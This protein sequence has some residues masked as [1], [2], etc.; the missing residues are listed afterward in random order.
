MLKALVERLF[1]RG[2]P[3][4]Y[5]EAR[6]LARN[7]PAE[8]RTEMAGRDDT[9]PEILYYLAKDPDPEVRRAVAAN[10][11]TPPHANLLLAADAN[12]KVRADLAGKIG[13]LAPGLTSQEQ[14]RLRRIT[15][16]TLET[17]ARDQIPKVRQIIA[18][19]LKDLADAPPEVIG[20]LARDAEIAV[21]APVLQYSPV[22]SD[23]DLLDIIATSPI[24]GALSAISRRREVASSVADAIA[25]S[26]DVAA[27]ADL[28]ANPLAQIR[29]ETLDHLA[30]RATDIECWHRPLVE[31]PH[32]SAKTAQKLARFVATNMLQTLAARR[33]LPP[34]AVG[35]VAL[36][37]RKRLDE[38]AATGPAKA[39]ARREADEA[40]AVARAR[41]LLS[42]GTLDETT[43]D[44]ALSGGDH[45]FVVAALSL[46]SGLPDAVVKKVVKTQSAK[47]IIAVTWKARLSAALAMQMQA[48]LLHLPASR[49]LR[50]AGPDFPLTPDEMEWQLEF[51][52]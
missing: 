49:I 16:D 18:E 25:A 20:R 9:R 37:V 29:E 26:N 4:A 43:I 52:G 27:I 17:L 12:E 31:R 1:R 10:G 39:E 38:M 11:A 3:L 7:G 28:L 50:A 45:A 2:K 35:A 22:L 24:P 33:D 5:E 42:N 40:S 8:V 19:T 47:G 15:Y 30:D 21:A 46:R 36:V 14:N 13:R 34:E 32:L 51:L 23:D 6:E 44:T 48:K 41:A